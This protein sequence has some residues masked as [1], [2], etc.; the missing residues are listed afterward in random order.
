MVLEYVGIVEFGEQIR[1][2]N[3]LDRFVCL[4]VSDAYFLQYF[5]FNRKKEDF[6]KLRFVLAFKMIELE[7]YKL[8]V[9]DFRSVTRNAVP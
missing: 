2:M 8:S 1:F 5:S 6:V 3:R 7:S 9:S 4:H